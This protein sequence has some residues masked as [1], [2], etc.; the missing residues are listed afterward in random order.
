[1]LYRI[2]ALIALWTLLKI[3]SYLPDYPDQDQQKRTTTSVKANT[4]TDKVKQG[5]DEGLSTMAVEIWRLKQRFESTY[6][7]LN[8]TTQKKI[9]HSFR[10]IDD[11]IDSMG[12]VIKDY[13]G[14]DYN[15]GLNVE[16]INIET[17]L[18][19]SDHLD[20]RRYVKEMIEPTIIIQGNLI[21]KGKVIVKE[22][23][24]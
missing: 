9:D 24:V 8:S 17:E 11:F 12:I 23:K 3:R 10:K 16:V 5:N 19:H 14:Q 22:E 20:T 7:R 4:C 6:D 1:M 13:T 2:A 21:N 15:D 18:E